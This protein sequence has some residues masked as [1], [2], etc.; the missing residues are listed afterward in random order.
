MKMNEA[1]RDIRSAPSVDAD[2]CKRPRLLPEGFGGPR[3]RQTA[4][5][6]GVIPGEGIGPEVIGAAWTVL[7]SV[8]LVTPDL[9]VRMRLG[10]AI[11]QSAIRQCGESLSPQVAT[12][13]REVFDDRGAI[14]TGPGGGRFVYDMRRMFDLYV[15]P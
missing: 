3:V 8:E 9:R 14:L 13:C 4:V 12:F 5:T 1:C 2:R 11:G 10:G 6:I 7:K 15:K